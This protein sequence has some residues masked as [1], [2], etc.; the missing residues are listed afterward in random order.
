MCLQRSHCTTTPKAP[1]VS[2]FAK[3]MKVKFQQRIFQ[4]KR[5]I[6]QLLQFLTQSLQKCIW[7]LFSGRIFFLLLQ[8]ILSQFSNLPKTKFFSSK[9]RKCYKRRRKNIIFQRNFPQSLSLSQSLVFISSFIYT[10]QQMSFFNPS[11]K[12]LKS[13]GLK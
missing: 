5:V 12:S 8:R 7:I 13:Q 1:T 10:V 11:S 3:L 6:F 9:L 4:G 2:S